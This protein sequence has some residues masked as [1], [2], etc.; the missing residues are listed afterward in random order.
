MKKPKTIIVFPNLN[1]A[2][3]DNNGNQ[4]PELQESLPT[5]LAQH[6]EKNGYDIN[7]CVIETTVWNWK[8][9]R[10]EDGGWNREQ[11]DLGS[12]ACEGKA[13]VDDGSANKSESSLS[14]G[15]A[16]LS[17]EEEGASAIAGNPAHVEA[18]TPTGQATLLPPEGYRLLVEGER[19]TQGDLYCRG[20]GHSWHETHLASGSKWTAFINYPMARKGNLGSGESARKAST[21]NGGKP[22]N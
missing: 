14:K 19:I 21:D 1:V 12:G 4:I 7:G 13:A 11:V 15:T 6:F 5:L 2:V 8:M 18:A 16:T 3:C 20:V 17:G 10:T 22:K 9:F